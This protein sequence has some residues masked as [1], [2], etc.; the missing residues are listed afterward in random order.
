MRSCNFVFVVIWIGGPVQILN[1]T[2]VR[3]VVLV[4]A[5]PLNAHPGMCGMQMTENS[6]NHLRLV[7][8]NAYTNR[9]CVVVWRR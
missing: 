7:R 9:F 4:N 3:F 2:E 6:D 5:D 8:C 1:P